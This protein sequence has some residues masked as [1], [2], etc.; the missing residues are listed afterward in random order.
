MKVGRF[1]PFLGCSGYPD[2]KNITSIVVSS[3]VKCP[4]CEAGQ[5]VERRTRKGGRVFWGCD[6]F[7]KCKMASW[8][9]PVDIKG[10]R[11]RVVDKEGNTVFHDEISK[12]K[13]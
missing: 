11:L 12:K 9:K 13:K 2:C 4:S 3:G 10:G 1:G 8:N 6:K 7:P 5:L